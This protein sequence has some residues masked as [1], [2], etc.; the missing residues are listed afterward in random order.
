[1]PAL[2][3]TGFRVPQPLIESGVSGGFFLLATNSRGHGMIPA[4]INDK[5]S[6]VSGTHEPVKSR[7]RCSCLV[8]AIFIRDAEPAEFQFIT[9]YFGTD[10]L[11]S[12]KENYI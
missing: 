5:L 7:S 2:Y 11:L 8:A 6:P 12:R 3:N 1:M 10:I 4:K 9:K